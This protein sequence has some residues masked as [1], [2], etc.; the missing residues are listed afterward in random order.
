[1][2]KAASSRTNYFLISIAALMSFYMLYNKALYNSGIPQFDKPIYITVLLSSII[3]IVIAITARKQL[4]ELRVLPIILSALIPLSFFISY[5]F[6]AS[7]YLAVNGILTALFFFMLF[8]FGMIVS[9]RQQALL[10]A[11]RLVLISGYAVVLFGLLNWFGNASFWGLFH[12]R[13]P[14]GEVISVFPD[15]VW[16]TGDGPRLSSVFQYP[17]TYAGYLIALTL[18]TAVSMAYRSHRTMSLICAFMMVPLFLSFF[19]TLSRGGLVFFPVVFVF[20]LFFLKPIKQ[21]FTLIYTAV[22]FVFTL[23]ILNPVN[24][25]GRSLQQTSS[26]ADYFVGCVWI[27][28]ASLLYVGFYW[29]FHNKAAA[30]FSRLS[31]RLQSVKFSSIYLPVAIILLGCLSLILLLST[32][33]S[34]LLPEDIQNRIEN[35]NFG[36]QTVQERGA[37]YS[38]ALKIFGDYPVFGVGGGAWK[39]LYQQY[40]SYPYISTQAHNFFVQHLVETGLVGF[41]LLLVLLVVILIAYIRSLYLKRMEQQQENEEHVLLFFIAAISLLAHSSIDFDMSYV[42]IAGLVFFSLGIVSKQIQFSIPKIELK[43]LSVWLVFVPS[44]IAVIL[45]GMLVMAHFNFE[46]TIKLS[47]TSTTFEE[48]VGPINSAVSVSKNPVYLNYRLSFYS[49][50]YAET[51]QPVYLEQAQKTIN[52][53]E[54][55]EPHDRSGVQ[56]IYLFYLQNNMKQENAD[57]L[58]KALQRFPWDVVLYEQAIVLYA[59]MG[60]EGDAAS[61]DN[62]INLYQQVVERVNIL[63]RRPDHLLAGQPFNVTKMMAS[64]IGQIYYFKKDFQRSADVLKSFIPE[65]YADE[66]DR[67]IT[68]LYLAATTKLNQ[69]DS[70]LYNKFITSY[71]EEKQTIQDLLRI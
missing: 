67:I 6:A 54:K 47:K 46:K 15:A 29:I 65:Q 26:A 39:A 56:S 52:D 45:S 3:F 49:Q 30:W 70:E 10:A 57:H 12:W 14:S 55:F 18:M 9:L 22:A 62:A 58:Q 25:L 44:L 19:L 35:I 1:M 24:Q 59:Q 69:Q 27:L 36:T 41:L 28:A 2:K 42:Y 50:A 53:F 16:F 68:R 34:K 38:D 21:W 32:G 4:N 60:N 51:K 8:I 66:T 61:W 33:L 64:A 13:N 31:Q 23:I 40:Q 43:K 37:F 17:N 48:I 20:L 5:F 71:P 63:N 11:S 7:H